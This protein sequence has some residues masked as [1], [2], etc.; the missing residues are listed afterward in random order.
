M[1]FLALNLTL[2]EGRLDKIM[3]VSNQVSCWS[4]FS[5]L[6]ECLPRCMY[7]KGILH[8][9]FIT[10]VRWCNSAFREPCRIFLPCECVVPDRVPDRVVLRSGSGVPHP[11]Q[12]L[13]PRVLHRVH[14]GSRVSAYECGYGLR[15][16][17]LC[18]CIVRACVSCVTTEPL[19]YLL[20]VVG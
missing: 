17:Y 15:V 16:C 8:V 10:G 14:L 1:Y 12:H 7:R 11:L 4:L 3:R 2:V 18:L 9:C 20:Y 6:C 5:F 19:G 13:R